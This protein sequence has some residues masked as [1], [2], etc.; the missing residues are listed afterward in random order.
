MNPI[1]QDILRLYLSCVIHTTMT[2]IRIVHTI[3]GTH[4]TNGQTGT[5]IRRRMADI[6]TGTQAPI[7]GQGRAILP[8][9]QCTT[10]KTTGE[11]SDGFI[12]RHTNTPVDGTDTDTIMVSVVC[13]NLRHIVRV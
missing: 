10:T 8:R 12:F 7:T 11:D 6:I 13:I 1:I 9:T 2:I 5:I 3:T 4:T